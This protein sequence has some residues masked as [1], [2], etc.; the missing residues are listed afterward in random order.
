ME[1]IANAHKGVQESYAIQ[2]GREIRIV[3][4]PQE[5]DDQASVTLTNNVKDQIEKDLTYPGK[6]KVTTIRELRAVEYVGDRPTKKEE[7]EKKSLAKL[8]S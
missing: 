4:K 7:K 8:S 2:A 6:I 3:V 1:A 5:L